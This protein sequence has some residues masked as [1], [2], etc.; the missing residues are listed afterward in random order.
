M[1]RW[2]KIARAHTTHTA[3]PAPA[4]K[5]QQEASHSNFIRQIVEADLMAGKFAK[6]RGNGKPGSALSVEQAPPDPAKIR[7]RFPPQPNGYLPY[8]HP[9]TIFLNFRL[10]RDHRGACPPP[11]PHT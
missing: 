2:S 7:T 8:G 3:M 10:P 5:P 1:R 4:K 9:K 11:V 6:R